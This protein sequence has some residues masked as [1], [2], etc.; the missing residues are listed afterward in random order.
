MKM[1]VDLT[2]VI[3]FALDLNLGLTGNYFLLKLSSDKF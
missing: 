2:N 1:G 3:R